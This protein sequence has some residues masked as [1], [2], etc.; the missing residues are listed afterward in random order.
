[1]K[2]YQY[3]TLLL[4]GM[5]ILSACGSPA[6]AQNTS[7]PAET[8][9]APSAA[10][11]PAPSGK[12]VSTNGVEF[13]IPTGLGTDA[14][15]T[16]IPEVVDQMTE[17]PAYL[18]FTL[19]GYT[20]TTEYSKP[21][22]RVIPIQELAKKNQGQDTL[23][24]L[25]AILANPVANPSPDITAMPSSDTFATV[26][27][28]A[29]L[30]PLSPSGINGVRM[31]AGFG[32]MAVMPITG[33]RVMYQFQ[34]L[35]TDGKFYVAVRMPLSVPFLSPDGIA[36]VPADGVQFNMDTMSS[37]GAYEAYAKQVS[38]RLAAAEAAG[39]LSPSIA[40]MDT[41]VQSLTVNSAAVVLPAPLPA[42]VEPPLAEQPTLT[43]V[44]G[45]CADSAKLVSEDPQ[46]GAKFKADEA[47]RKT[48]NLINTGTCTWDASY[49]F[50]FVEGEQMASSGVIKPLVSNAITPGGSLSIYIDMQAPAKQG[51]HIGK[52]SWVDAAG[53]TVPVTYLEVIS[54]VIT[55]KITTKKTDTGAT[56]SITAASIAIVQEQGSGAICA[57]NSTYF[58]YAYITAN[59]ATT[60]NYEIHASSS[61]GQIPAGNLDSLSS[62]TV[63]FDQAGDKTIAV[64]LT[65]PYSYP[66]DITVSLRVNDGKWYNTK[67]ACQ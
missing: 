8:P 65:G 31:L 1:M 66:D 36:P 30:K 17:F 38:E 43:P 53:K 46:D 64:R 58:V 15:G 22:V 6:P 56:G 50:V 28:A 39:T 14:S 45:A 24:K 57:A 3:L 60:A 37:A 55:V 41:F 11:T 62:G 35:T 29:N 51:E 18:E 52:W 33:D 48:W 59:G 44:A 27:A 9:A 40:L 23:V 4:I 10:E 12:L 19:Q 7:Q 34:G 25:R 16:I 26:V 5:L 61:G 49:Q 54:N 32:G 42:A 20:P 63:T 13:T 47:F 67:L 2:R 21:Q